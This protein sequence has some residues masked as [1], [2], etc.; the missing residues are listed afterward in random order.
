MK[1]KKVL[2]F[3]VVAALGLSFFTAC[4]NPIIKK[5]WVQDDTNTEPNYITISQ[6]I[7]EYIY[8]TIV[9]EMPTVKIQNINVIDVQYILYSGDQQE[10]NADAKLGANTSI[11]TEVKNANNKVIV[12]LA[13]ELRDHPGYKLILHGHANPLT[14]DEG[15]ITELTWLSTERAKSALSVLSNFYNDGTTDYPPLPCSI[16][17]PAD[18]SFTTTTPPW[19]PLT[20]RIIA[21]GYGGERTQ[22]SA[23]P[24]LNR[25]VEAI[26]YEIVDM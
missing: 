13:E 17:L 18:P 14:S 6:N 8:E 19:T 10:Y 9:A 12:Q 1:Y 25:R 21:T 4:E 7:T 2:I 3:L 22:S 16:P 15:E 5:W 23:D 26:L 24:N 20:D 11:T